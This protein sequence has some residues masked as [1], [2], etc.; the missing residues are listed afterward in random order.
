MSSVSTP[1]ELERVSN[2][3]SRIRR[4]LLWKGASQVFGQVSQIVVA[5]V[6]A[7]LLTPRDYG[8]A[9]MVLVFAGLVPIF[10]DLALG[11]ALVQRRVLE[12]RDRSTV[13]WFSAVAGLAFTA[14]GIALSWPLAAFYGEPEVQ[15][16]FTV[17]SLGFV[18]RALGTTHAALL[19]RELDFRSLELRMMA[20][21]AAGG[22]VGITAALA[23]YGPWSIIWQ[24]TAASI[25]STLLLW[26][27]SSWRPH[28]VFSRRVLREMGGFSANVFGTRILFYFNRNVDNILIGRV[29]GAKALGAYALAYN[30]MLMPLSWLASSIV[31]VMFPAFA[32][33]QDDPRRVR[34][35]WFRINRIVGSVTIPGMLGLIAVAPEFVNVVFGE[36]WQSAGPVV[37]VLAWVGLLQSLQ[38]LNSSI[39][40]ARDRTRTLLWYA[41]VALAASLVAFVAGLHWGIVGVAAAYAITSSFVEPYYTHLTAKTLGTSAFSFLRALSGVVQA[42]VAMFAAVLAAKLLLAGELGDAALLLALIAVGAVVYVPLCAWRAPEVIDELR[43]LR[44]RGRRRASSPARIQRVEPDTVP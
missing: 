25:T 3:G 42:S 7:R 8:L 39:L 23:G 16:L 4:G 13:F 28:L 22:V 17:L 29:L 10:S 9:A 20:G 15:P 21:N 12:E 33:M 44:H 11:A 40:Q 14:G 27:L 19:S 1:H 38:S 30:V 37:Q 32:R 43:A 18:I 35:M 24:Q 41:F 6:L 34:S 36:R 2:M 5:V 31:E 26:A